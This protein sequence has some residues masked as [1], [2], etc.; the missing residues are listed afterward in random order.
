M[1]LLRYA[2]LLIL[3]LTCFVPACVSST[4]Q[5]TG[6]IILFDTNR[7]GNWEIYSVG[8]DGSNPTRITNSSAQDYGPWPSPDGLQ[9]VFFSRPSRV[10]YIYTMDIDGQN[11]TKLD[12]ISGAAAGPVWSPDGSRI[13]FVSFAEADAEICTINVDGTDLRQLTD[14]TSGDFEP[15]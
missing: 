6:D 5:P 15:T 9:I 14:N 1:K 8:A 2:P 3:L 12:G 13:A 4:D 11:V 7:D 10:N